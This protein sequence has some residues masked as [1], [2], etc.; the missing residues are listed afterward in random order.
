[1]SDLRKLSV[2]ELMKLLKSFT[3]KNIQNIESNNKLIKEFSKGSK[4]NDGVK[5]TIRLL[6]SNNR[7]LIE[8][9]KNFISLYN[10]LVEFNT[11]LID[12]FRISDENISGF[13]DILK[14]TE[15]QDDLDLATKSLDELQEL[16]QKYIAEEKYEEC[17]MVK[18]LIEKNSI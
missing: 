17:R 10:N 5:N 15:E 4:L 9:N 8:E 14:L 11:Y 12:Q 1:M 2:E 7:G 16:L 6:Y 18:L 3:K 13:S